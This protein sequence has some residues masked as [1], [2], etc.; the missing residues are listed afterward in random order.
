M[1]HLPIKHRQMCSNNTYIFGVEIMKKAKSKI[2]IAAVV[3]AAVM[4]GGFTGIYL[5]ETSMLNPESEKSIIRCI[6]HQKLSKLTENRIG[7]VKTIYKTQKHGDYF[8]VLYSKD[9]QESENGSTACFASFKKDDYFKKRYR[10]SG[11]SGNSTYEQVHT[12]T[13]YD[14]KDNSS[15]KITCV[16][17][18]IKSENTKCSVFETDESLLPIKKLDEVDIP[19]SN[20]ILIKK[21]ELESRDNDITVYDGS[22]GLEL[23]AGE[24]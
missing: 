4:I 9:V 18:N 7:P 15:T 6:N 1:T 8:F 21:Y 11:F 12:Y 16:L 5:F 19:Q 2:I 10:Y 14:E 22:I 23:L 17:A 13:Y 20:Y 3:L 24:E